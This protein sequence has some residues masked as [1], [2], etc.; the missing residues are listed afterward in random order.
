MRNRN[1]GKKERKRIGEK[2]TV[3]DN[4]RTLGQP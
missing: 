3:I 1:K 4:P 2:W